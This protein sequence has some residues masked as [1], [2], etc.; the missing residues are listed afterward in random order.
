MCKTSTFIIGISGGSGAG[1]TTVAIS[2]AQHLGHQA[3]LISHD[4]YY[5]HMPYGNYD[6][7]EALDTELMLT[8]LQNLKDGQTAEL[9]I[10]DMVRNQRKPKTETV[11][12]SP[13]IIVE[14][15]FVLAIPQILEQLDFKIYIQTPQLERLNRRLIRDAGEKLRSQSSI[16][17]EWQTNVMPTHRTMVE[18]GMDIADLVVSGE[19]PVMET[20]ELIM[21]N[22]RLDF[23]E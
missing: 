12:S 14:G 9:P 1:K 23:S 4:R 2:L 17:N 8:H 16:L 11:R 20:V 10:Y 7:P 22:L 5:F 21:D 15:I 13:V 19:T 3:V 6:T 18:Q